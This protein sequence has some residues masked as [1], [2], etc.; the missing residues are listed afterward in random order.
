[1]IYFQLL[2]VDVYYSLKI[3][4]LSV[5]KYILNIDAV[6]NLLLVVKCEEVEICLIMML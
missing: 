3:L 6:I 2:S 1:M 5:P 4:T